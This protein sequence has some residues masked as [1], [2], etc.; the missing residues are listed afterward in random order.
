M[1]NPIDKPVILASAAAGGADYTSIVY[2][3]SGLKDF[4]LHVKFS[5]STLNGT[6][7]LQASNDPTVATDPSTADWVTVVNSSQSV[8]SGASHIWNVEK[9]NYKYVRFFWDY[10]SGAGTITAWLEVKY[11]GG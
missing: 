2:E 1:S 10:T 7:T 3:L 4:S 6:L 9:A 11:T 8:S 5:S